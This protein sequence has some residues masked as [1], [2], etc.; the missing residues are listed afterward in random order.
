[1][2]KTQDI[3]LATYLKINGVKY[4]TIEPSDKYNSTFVFE[5]PPQE[6]LTKWFN[7]SGKIQIIIDTYRSLLRDARIAQQNVVSE[8]M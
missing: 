6:L 3:K 4:I 8:K 7:D 5:Q 1:M 2:F